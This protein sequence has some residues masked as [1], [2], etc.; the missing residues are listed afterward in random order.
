MTTRTQHTDLVTVDSDSKAVRKV[1]AKS[2]EL[3]KEVNDCRR[4]VE[5]TYWRLSQLLHKVWDESLYIE[6]GF[7]SWREYVDQELGFGMRKAQYLV[8][9]TQWVRALNPDVQKWISELGWTKAK[10][11][12]GR[13]TNE[14]ATEWKR[15]VEGKTVAQI[16]EALKAGGEE[17]ASGKGDKGKGSEEGQTKDRAHKMAFT[18]HREQTKNVVAALEKASE[19]SGSE[20]P[21]HNLDNICVEFLANNGT[22]LNRFEFLKRCEAQ[23]E[24]QIV[25]Y[26]P[27][28][29]EGIGAVVYGD[30]LLNQ[31]ADSFEWVGEDE[32]GAGA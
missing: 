26:D 5:V 13:V 10:E 15:K 22:V 7:S 2:K 1:S 24:L 29:S 20:K 9:I 19:I 4:T 14:N 31:L 8:G 6:W 30:K 25:A 11:L 32:A 18:L 16:Q 3:R 21:G 28:E 12:T 23:T 17:E 27:K